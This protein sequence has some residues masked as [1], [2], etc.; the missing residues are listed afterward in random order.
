MNFDYGK[1]CDIYGFDF[2]P[3]FRRGGDSCFPLS[4]TADMVKRLKKLFGNTRP[5]WVTLQGYDNIREANPL[6]RGRLSNYRETRCIAYSSI[7]EGAKG[8]MFWCYGMS[9]FGSI[10]GWPEW[11][12]IKAVVRELSIMSPV[13][14]AAPCDS[15]LKI[16]PENKAHVCARNYAGDY[17]IFAASSFE[18]ARN[19]RIS[20]PQLKYI[21]KLRVIG[22]NRTIKVSNGVIDDHFDKYAVHIYSSTRKSLTIPDI[23]KA[24]AKADKCISDHRA[25]NMKNILFR[26]F[27]NDRDNLKITTASTFRN[28][29]GILYFPFDGMKNSY[30][31][32]G[33][34]NKWPD[35]YQV[36]FKTP[37]KIG[38]IVIYTSR[39]TIYNDTSTSIKDYELQAW[40]D[41]K[42]ETLDMVKDNHQVRIV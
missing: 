6:E 30:W 42:W 10:A 39:N 26:L 7:I 40:K 37:Q 36:E 28:H 17:Y 33:T 35:W 29:R 1:A 38:R 12:G 41:G 27:E 19:L 4:T 3:G 14:L 34:P 9:I 13:I 21:A 31:F 25:R 20:M 22:E 32:D 2:Y 18:K 24:E 16:S 8:I 23:N 5:I 15:H 11:D